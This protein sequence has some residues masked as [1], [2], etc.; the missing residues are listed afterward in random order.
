MSSVSRCR[1]DSG[2]IIKASP[3]S[4]GVQERGDPVVLD[5]G[6]L[7]LDCTS[8]VKS[9]DKDSCSPMSHDWSVISSRERIKQ[10]TCRRTTHTSSTDVVTGPASGENLPDSTRDCKIP[11]N[12]M[13]SPKEGI[14]RKP[15]LSQKVCGPF[16]CKVTIGMTSVLVV[17]DSAGFNSS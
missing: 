12:E 2:S 8:E 11:R 13:H 5:R 4:Y 6:V 16:L 10:A 17:V 1:W 9:V 15:S 3:A 14:S 7:M